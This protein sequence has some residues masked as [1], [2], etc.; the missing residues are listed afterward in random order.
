VE[1]DGTPFQLYS[2]EEVS[3]DLELGVRLHAAGYKSV[4]V[5]ERL[6]T[7]EVS[8]STFVLLLQN[9]N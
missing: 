8:W 3:E 6:S 5:C 9:W 4:L 1:S 2:E 7:G